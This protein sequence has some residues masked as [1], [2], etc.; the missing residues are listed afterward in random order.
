MAAGLGFGQ[1]ALSAQSPVS[2]DAPTG[3]RD[4]VPGL[5]SPA[6]APPSGQSTLNATLFVP[7][8]AVASPAPV[9]LAPS[10]DPA[11]ASV[12]T[13][14]SAR[15]YALSPD[16]SDDIRSAIERAI[17]HMSF[18]TRPIARRRLIRAN[19]PS[20]TLTFQVRSDTLV[21]TFVDDNPIVTPLAGGAVP[22]HRRSTS[23]MYDVH[24][25]LVGDTLRQ[26]I[27]TDDGE[28]DNDFVFLEGGAAIEMHVTLRAERL[29][30]PL[31]YIAVYREIRPPLSSSTDHQQP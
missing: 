22:W 2:P 8:I 21:V 25:A 1:S 28:R 27:A 26:T 23:E 31:R 29:P 10:V 4:S 16:E 5:A 30:A 9:S 6:S 14:S 3:A 11:M 20:P 15:V 7:T 17:A 12:L 13:D 24:I 18:I 19:R